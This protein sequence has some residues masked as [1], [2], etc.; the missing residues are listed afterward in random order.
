MNDLEG[1]R[2]GARAWSGGVGALVLVGFLGYQ[3]G[4][5]H[6][7]NVW[8]NLWKTGE[9]EGET[10]EKPGKTLGNSMVLTCFDAFT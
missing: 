1:P 9:K 7:E 8:K 6:Q 5:K 2:W 4:G 10:G 3:K